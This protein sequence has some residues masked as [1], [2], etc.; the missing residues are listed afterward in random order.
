MSS[1]SSIDEI[2]LS[3]VSFPLCIEGRTQGFHKGVTGI[4]RKTG[5]LRKKV[6]C[7]VRMLSRRALTGHGVELNIG[8]GDRFTRKKK[9]KKNRL[10]SIKLV[11]L[12]AFA[13]P[14]LSIR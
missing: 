5:S 3:G 4:A 12:F 13:S 9:K 6:A 2:S 1:A 10:N 14:F 11:D 7:F 8:R